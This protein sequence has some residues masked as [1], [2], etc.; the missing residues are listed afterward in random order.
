LPTIASTLISYLILWL[1][2]RKHLKTPAEANVEDIKIEN[3]PYLV[4]GLVHLSVCTV[5]LAIGPYVGVDMWIIS[6]VS[7]ISL[8]VCL[9]IL[10]LIKLL[11][12]K[13][14]QIP[15]DNQENAC[16]E[17]P[18]TSSPVLSCLKRAPWQLIPF[19]L[20]MFIM[21]L[22]FKNQGITEKIGDLLG[23]DNSI[24]KYGVVSYLSA[25]LIN[26]I[27]MSVLFCPI[28]EGLTG[29]TATGA[30]YATIVGS[31]LGALLT[32]IGALAGI[33]WSSLLKKHDVKLSFA[34]FVKYG[35]MIS[36]PSLA[37]NLAILFVII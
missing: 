20:S 14:A 18:A 30:I 2:F 7:A 24:F 12:H 32:P 1:I 5:A 34:Q 8:F 22:A 36:I 25:N 4:I 13:K 28:M 23:A 27:P 16:D 29:A 31:N 11:R 17:K 37:A 10:N 33:M 19:V 6:F 3:K 26:N 35:A 15:C 9:G 21:V